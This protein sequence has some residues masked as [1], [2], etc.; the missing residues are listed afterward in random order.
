VRA[1]QAGPRAFDLG[2]SDDAL[3][4]VNGKPLFRGEGSYSYDEPRREGLIGY[5]Q[6]R[7]FLPLVEGDNDLAVV[8][9]DGFGGWGLMGRFPDPSG[10]VVDAQ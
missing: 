4:L 2:F 1:A 8:V 7:V 5:D 3:V 6:A 9:Q 10:L